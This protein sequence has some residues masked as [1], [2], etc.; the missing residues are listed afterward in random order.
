MNGWNMRHGRLRRIATRFVAAVLLSTVI[1]LLLLFGAEKLSDQGQGVT[2]RALALESSSRSSYCTSP[3]K[4]VLWTLDGSCLK[5][6]HFVSPPPSSAGTNRT[7]GFCGESNAYLRSLRDEIETRYKERCEE[8]VVFGAALGSGYGEWMHERSFF[9][10]NSKLA[11]D[12]YGTC[13]FQFIEDEGGRYSYSVD[14][15]QIL[16]PLNL[17][18]FP[19][20][21]NRRNVKVLKLNPSLFS[22]G[23]SV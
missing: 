9:S 5:R 14:K 3:E 7:C 6:P 22:L 15:S 20:R 2:L 10:P 21:N 13:F 12:R 23:L 8:L 1:S 19:Y 17:S 16:I 4:E 18:K 11:A